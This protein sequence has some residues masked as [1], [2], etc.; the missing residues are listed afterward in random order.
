[1]SDKNGSAGGRPDVAALR[2]DIRQTRADLGETVQALAAKA[3]VKARAKEQ[4]EQTKQRAR[5]QVH[6]A[7]EKVR[8]N[9]VPF[10]AAL[11]AGAALVGII[12]I[13][14]GRLK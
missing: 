5:A 13:V 4:V 3:D 10:A 6:D 2:E 11:V 12:L 9:P 7:S 8:R 14:R 1:M